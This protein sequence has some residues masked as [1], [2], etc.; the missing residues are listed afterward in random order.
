ML[1]T[2]A[3]GTDLG[4]LHKTVNEYL[5]DGWKPQGGLFIDPV[6]ELYMQPLVRDLEDGQKEN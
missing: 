5:K 3:I 6:T 4:K 2:I 1:Y